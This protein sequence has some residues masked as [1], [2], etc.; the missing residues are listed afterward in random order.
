[1]ISIIEADLEKKE[2]EKK[3]FD[4]APKQQSKY[5][6][7]KTRT[8]A[9]IAGAAG[10]G[11]ALLVGASKNNTIKKLRDDHADRLTDIAINR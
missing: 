8:A 11:G 5:S 7:M 2:P 4:K 6:T 10:L 3:I 9:G 1:M